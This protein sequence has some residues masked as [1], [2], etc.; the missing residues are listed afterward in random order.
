[1]HDSLYHLVFVSVKVRQWLFFF[2]FFFSGC[3][4]PITINI[5]A[6]SFLRPSPTAA[7]VGGNV[8]TSQRVT[9]V[10]LKAFR[11]VTIRWIE[12]KISFWNS[13]YTFYARF[14]HIL[15]FFPSHA[16]CYDDLLS[17]YT[18][19]AEHV[20]R[21]KDVW[22]ILLLAILIWGIMRPLLEEQELDPH[23]KDVQQYTHIWP[24]HVSL[25]RKY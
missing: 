9:D 3:L 10:V 5:P 25:M 21:R 12:I 8:L 17:S 7:V 4:A 15:T 11:L 19:F 23:G 6:G 14:N 2:F 18:F 16:S 1:M 22:T 13:S 24:I 20:P